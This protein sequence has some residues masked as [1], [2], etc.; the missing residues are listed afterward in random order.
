[1]GLAVAFVL[2]VLRALQANL[3]GNMVMMV[4]DCSV[5]LPLYAHI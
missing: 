4:D 2:K 3:P 5:T 1:M